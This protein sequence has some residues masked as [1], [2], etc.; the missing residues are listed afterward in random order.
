MTHWASATVPRLTNRNPLPAAASNVAPAS[1]ASGPLL[2]I[3]KLNVTEFVLG[4]LRTGQPARAECQIRM[5]DLG[6]S[7]HRRG[8][9]SSRSRDNSNAQPAAILRAM[10]VLRPA[11][12][13][14]TRSNH[15]LDRSATR[16][17]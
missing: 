14:E 6:H 7:E 8:G 4:H 11:F 13:P 9:Y 17:L 15:A 16:P 2:V 3:V 5:G 12:L 10:R 1:A